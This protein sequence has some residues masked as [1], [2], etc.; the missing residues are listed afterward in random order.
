MRQYRGQIHR[1]AALNED[2]SFEAI[3]DAR[4]QVSNSFWR[5]YYKEKLNSLWSRLRGH[6]NHLHTLAQEAS[7]AAIKSRH[8]AGIKSV[9]IDEIH[10]SEGRSNDFDAEFRPITNHSKDR[11]I[12]L[13]AARQIGVTL[14]PIDLVQVGNTYCV[15]DGHHRLS[16]ARAYGQLEVDAQITVWE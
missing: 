3:Q 10:C 2:S 7:Q 8:Q 4:A 6:D 9:S 12:G 11:W 5:A 1:P 14:P 16:V 15:R 13:A